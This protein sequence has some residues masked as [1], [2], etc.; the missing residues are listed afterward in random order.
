MEYC[1]HIDTKG[2]LV[3]ELSGTITLEDTLK[4][5]DDLKEYIDSD[6]IYDLVVH[7]DDS[8]FLL[9]S[10]D[11]V[12]LVNH[13]KEGLKRYKKGAIAFVS[14]KDLIFGVCRQLQIQ[15]ENE[16]IQICVF[17]TTQTAT[18]WINEIKS[19]NQSFHRTR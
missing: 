6:E 2:I 12:I 4:V 1:R 7:S 13:V 18:N 14:C 11:A 5:F 17:R 3:T 9:S 16:F 19:S 8:E 10:D 15:T